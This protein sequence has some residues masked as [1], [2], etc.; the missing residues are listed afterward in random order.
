MSDYIV[1]FAAQ[2]SKSAEAAEAREAQKEEEKKS[3][4]K[5]KLL[6]QQPTFRRE[7]VLCKIDHDSNDCT[8]RGQLKCPAAIYPT[9]SLID[10]KEGNIVRLVRLSDRCPVTAGAGARFE[11]FVIGFR[12]HEQ[13]VAS[14]KVAADP[15]RYLRLKP[16]AKS[17]FTQVFLFPPYA[18]LFPGFPSFP[19]Y[20]FSFPDFSPYAFLFPGFSPY[21]FLFP[22]FP[23]FPPYAFLFPDFPGPQ[24]NIF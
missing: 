10:L 1:Q 15:Q 3:E 6:S 4:E 14:F 22:G 23:S 5:K 13:K 12:A 7:A 8:P 24:S 18:F 21:A 16:K 19:P 17:K 11:L 2:E 20:A 9:V